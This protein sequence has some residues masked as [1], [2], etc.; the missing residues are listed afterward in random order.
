MSSFSPNHLPT[1]EVMAISEGVGLQLLIVLQWHQHLVDQLTQLE[2]KE[3]D[4]QRTARGDTKAR[5][6]GHVVQK[7]VGEQS[8]H[9]LTGTDDGQ[10]PQDPD[11]GHLLR[12]GAEVPWGTKV[13]V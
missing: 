8:R 12:P 9:Q 7:G 2:G 4:Q 10:I 13:N 5:G 3:E 6:E 11:D 1:Y